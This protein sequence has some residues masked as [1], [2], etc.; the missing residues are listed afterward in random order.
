MCCCSRTTFSRLS[1]TQR[2]TETI[3]PPG[4]ESTWTSTLTSRY[5]TLIF[6]VSNIYIAK[7]FHLQ[8]D[9]MGGHINNYLLEK[10]RVTNQQ[11]GENNFHA[12]Y[13]LLKGAS[14]KTLSGLKLTRN[15][16]DYVYL[17]NT[18]VRQMPPKVS[19]FRS[20]ASAFRS[21][22]FSEKAVDSIWK[23][24]AIILH[25]GNIQF[26]A[27]DHDHASLQNEKKSLLHIAKLL[28]VEADDLETALTTRVIA[29]S[30][31]VQKRANWHQFRYNF[32]DPF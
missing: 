26:T 23:L 5:V 4:L 20:V 8:G 24:I 10:S 12:F 6:N 25:I 18:N 1:E 9:P 7:H 21:L 30:G 13:Q 16:I 22:D 19:D 28:D 32:H 15:P 14:E 29:A 2:R 31:E 3:I 11:K 17:A 27:D